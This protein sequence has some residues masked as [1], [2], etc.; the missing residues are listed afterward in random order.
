VFDVYIRAAVEKGQ[1]LFPEDFCFKR[2]TPEDDNKKSL[3]EISSVLGP[4]LYAGNYFNNPVADDLVEFKD[5]WFHEYQYE[6]VKDKL[7]QAKCFISIDPATRTNQSNDPTGIVV[8][9]LDLDGYV[10][11]VDARAKKLRPNEL[12]DEIFKMVEIYDPD[13]VIIE[14]V[15]AQILW[16]DL[17]KQ[18]MKRQ[19][20][21]FR[22][23]EYDPGTKETKSIKI[24]KLIPYYARGQVLHKPGLVEMER[25][26]REFPRNANDDLID[27]LQA[28]IPYWKGTVVSTPKNLEKYSSAWWDALRAG[29]KQSSG[30]AQEKLFD[31]YRKSKPVQT[32]NPSW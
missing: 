19:N 30:T 16:I 17:L 10:Y 25:Q 14:T 11:V 6:A 5:E 27:A 20:K 15:S 31:E 23:E 8:T 29:N 1:L 12:I 28:Q 21:R 7:K 3:E 26:L 9:K 32:R 18:E 4:Y 22:L 13:V 2:E 24:R